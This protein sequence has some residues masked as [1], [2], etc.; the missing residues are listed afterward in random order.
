ME[1]LCTIYSYASLVG[2]NEL[3]ET[4]GKRTIEEV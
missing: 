1:K 2:T 3:L 4:I